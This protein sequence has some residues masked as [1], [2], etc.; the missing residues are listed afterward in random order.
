MMGYQAIAYFLL[1]S[2]ASYKPYQMFLI[3]FAI[4]LFLITTSI[5]L[6]F[7]QVKK[8]PAESLASSALLVVISP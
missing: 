4:P 2:L 3:C 1:F 6:I 5:G 7:N 8:E